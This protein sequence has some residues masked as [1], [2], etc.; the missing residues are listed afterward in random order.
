MAPGW[1]ADGAPA[2]LRRYA[3]QKALPVAI[4]TGRL[5][6]MGLRVLHA[7]LADS[8]P[9]IRHSP[10]RTAALVVKLARL[11]RRRRQFAGS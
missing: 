5:D 3:A 7:D 8:G 10:E 2:A 9:K 6:A 1:S 11:G 4:D